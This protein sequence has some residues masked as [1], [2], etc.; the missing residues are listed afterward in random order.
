M[1]AAAV[2]L[3]ARSKP[4]Q[5]RGELRARASGEGSGEATYEFGRPAAPKETWQGF[6]NDARAALIEEMEKE[7]SEIDVVWAALEIACEDDAVQTRSVVKLPIQAYS[8]RLDTMVEELIRLHL[9]KLDNPSPKEVLDCV[10]NYL[11]NLQKFKLA[12]GWLEM[13]SPYRLYT[14]NVLAQKCGTALGLA[15]VHLGLLQRLQRRGA[16]EGVEYEL[17][18]PSTGERPF[19]RAS[20]QGVEAPGLAGTPL[21]PRALVIMVLD[22]LKR[23]FWPWEWAP[24]AKSGF[25]PAAE[26]A[27]GTAGRIGT[28]D[29]TTGV[30]QASGRPFGDLGRSL[31]A[32]ER[33]VLLNGPSLHLR[34][35]GIV[36][37]HLKRY[38]ES[39]YCLKKYKAIL[40]AS[41]DLEET[42]EVA[43]VQTKASL[44]GI[45]TQLET[46]AVEESLVDG[47]ITKLERI[48]AE[49][50]WAL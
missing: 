33:L 23:S 35:S 27:L 17:V 16:L 21:P 50:S 9:P 41:T 20:G 46:I 48:K 19:A 22:S 44:E 31:V 10:D 5:V 34:D 43:A 3:P 2:C 29:S 4:R 42:Q 37:Y 14:H 39:Y 40:E 49:S 26:A 32:L 7:E 45:R 25:L 18:L 12:E 36:L 28:A 38:E 30:L 1:R 6:A 15:V 8:K 47:V 11:Y 13:F 24:G